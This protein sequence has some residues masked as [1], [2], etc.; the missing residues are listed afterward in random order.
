[1]LFIFQFFILLFPI[2]FLQI[3]RQPVD[4]CV[5]IMIFILLLILFPFVLITGNGLI[6][7]AEPAARTGNG[8]LTVITTRP[9]AGTEGRTAVVRTAAAASLRLGLRLG[10]RLRSRA[11]IKDVSIQGDGVIGAGGVGGCY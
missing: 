3:S 10:L 9:S 8:V 11:C 5:T 4:A 6:T 7:A 2:Y 1:M